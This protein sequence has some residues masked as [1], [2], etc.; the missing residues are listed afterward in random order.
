[1]PRQTQDANIQTRAARAR[2]PVRHKPFFRAVEPGLHL[3]YRKLA[4]GRPGMWIVRRYLGK[5]AYA[6]ENLRTA[7]RALVLADDHGEADGV[8]VMTYVQAT[9]AARPQ[10]RAPGSYTV[11]E[12]LDD[13]LAYLAGRSE[14]AAAAARYKIER[15]IRPELGNVKVSALTSARLRQWRDAL[16]A[17]PARTRRGFRP[18]PS[19]EDGRRARKVSTNRTLTVLRAA[20]NLAFREGKVESDI[21][22]RRVEAFG[23][24]ESARAR[25]LTVAEAQRLMNSCD[26]IF[27][28]LV[29]AALETG[30]RY[31]ELAR[32]QC[33]DFN[34]D[35]GT[36]TVRQ[37][38]SGKPRYVILTPEGAAFFQT[39]CAA[40]ASDAIIFTRDDGA[41][42]ADSNQAQ[43]MQIACE[44][45]KIR[46]PIG[47]HG[48]RHTWASL[49]VMAGVPLVVVAQQ[50]GHRDTQMVQRHYAH[51]AASYVTDAIRDGAPRFGEPEKKVVPIGKVVK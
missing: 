28:P 7:D 10:R 6:V 44:R 8:L 27:R 24:V 22:W 21:E 14:R 41:P 25:Y 33:H 38:K 4:S 50:L 31:Q 12:A 1:M 18:A 17:A 36:L 19:T 32:L 37:S 49:A 46:P 42:W 51:L 16:A 23:G 11:G 47:F 29:R 43:R 5:G 3:G 13:Y 15:L 9:R 40:R 20:L 2:L 45:A 30:C 39:A 48:L 34:P 26:P 35:A